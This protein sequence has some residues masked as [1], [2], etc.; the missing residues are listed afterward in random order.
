MEDYG[1]ID[2]D[3]RAVAAKEAD[4]RIAFILQDRWIGHPRADEVLGRI[5]MAQQTY[6]RGRP[7]SLLIVGE[8]G[9][10]K[11]MIRT[12]YQRDQRVTWQERTG[13]RRQP[14]LS[15]Q[16]PPEPLEAKF[17]KAALDALDAPAENFSRTRTVQDSAVSLLR[18][19]K[20]ELL[21]VDEIQNVFAG[22]ARQQRLFLN[23]LRWLINELRLPIVVFGT[24]E[25]LDVFGGDDQLQRRFQAVRMANWFDD[26]AGFKQ[27]VVL[28]E[29]TLPLRKSGE[30]GTGDALKVLLEASEGITSNLCRLI[31]DAAVAAIR[32]GDERVTVRLL[33]EIVGRHHGAVA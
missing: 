2:P 26:L 4:D 15:F 14:V 12:K 16:M 6:G 18:L 22:T 25:A 27:F 13:V 32:D 10:G 33:R 29:R 17:F 21:M 31:E 19:V 5:R 9:I 8:S 24:V 30:L 7:L 11:T 20:V 1:H 28:M 3:F 23:N